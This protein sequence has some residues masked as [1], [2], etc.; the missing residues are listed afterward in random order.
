MASG[1]AVRIENWEDVEDQFISE[2]TSHLRIFCDLINDSSHDVRAWDFSGMNSSPY[3]KPFLI[4]IKSFWLRLI[5][6][7]IFIINLLGFIK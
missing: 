7:K 4:L 6:K 2:D 1:H 5:N 3:N